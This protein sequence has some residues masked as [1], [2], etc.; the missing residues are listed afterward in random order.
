MSNADIPVPP[1]VEA[2]RARREAREQ[3]ARNLQ[4]TKLIEQVELS[5]GKPVARIVVHYD[6]KTQDTLRK[7]TPEAREERRAKTREKIRTNRQR[8]QRGAGA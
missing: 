6:D 8:R 1:H 2:R 3:D 5:T 4:A 7:E